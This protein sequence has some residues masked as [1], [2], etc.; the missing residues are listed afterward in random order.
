M[1]R[2]RLGWYND[3]I[4][5]VAVLS[6]SERLKAQCAKRNMT[7]EMLAEQMGVSRQTISRWQLGESEPSFEHLTKLSILL[8]VTLDELFADELAALQNERW[9]KSDIEDLEGMTNALM[10]LTKR[11]TELRQKVCAGKEKRHEN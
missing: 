4:Q 5:G 7:Q 1:D 11:G 3:G 2:G 6:F 9:D 8:E 10:I